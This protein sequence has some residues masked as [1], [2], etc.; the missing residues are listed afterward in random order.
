MGCYLSAVNLAR[1]RHGVR[2][3]V[4]DLLV[5]LDRQ[6]YGREDHPVSEALSA[7]H[8]IRAAALA[9]LHDVTLGG[10]VPVS[11]EQLANDF[12]VGGA[13]FPLVDRG[14]GIRKPAGWRAALSITTS[15]PRAGRSRPYDDEEGRDGLHR[16]KLRRDQGGAAENEALRAAI[17][18][19]LP[20]A[21]FYGVQP[22]IFQAIYPVYVIGEEP[23]LE[24]FVLALTDD[25]RTVR[26]G[27][28]V[29][30]AFRR[31]LITE[32]RR[33]LHQPVFASQ[34]MLAYDTHCAVCALGHRELLDAAHI[35]PDTDARG[36]PVVPNGLAL[37]KIHHAAYDQN[38]LGIRPDY[39]VEIHHRLLEELNGPMLRHGLQEHHGKP[40]M[41]VP[42]H[43]GDR[44]D[45]ERL[46]ER[47]GQFR[48]A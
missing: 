31:Y 46:M 11:R 23:A 15:A 24:Q 21:W 9:W 35:I 4:E 2:I 32:T 45:P 43:H 20:L 38:I 34:V 18:D 41:Q 25:Q 26:P 1:V 39:I 29:E 33:R 44:P 42:R 12:Q 40:L 36:L 28:P 5:T 48:V 14:R 22:G 19:Q 7:E 47:Y 13:R 17:R 37:C 3:G 30:A 10:T 27:S 6:Y 8:A 16:Y